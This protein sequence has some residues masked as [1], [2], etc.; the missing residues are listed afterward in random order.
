MLIKKFSSK[1][2]P[3]DFSLKGL[4]QIPRNSYYCERWHQAKKGERDYL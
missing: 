3:S 1:I 2:T 4:V